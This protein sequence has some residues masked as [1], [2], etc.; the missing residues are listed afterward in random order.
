MEWFMI[1]KENGGCVTCIAEIPEDP[2]AIV[3]VAHGFTSC[4]ESATGQVLMQHLPPAGIGVVAYDQPG[5]GTDAARFEDLRI[6]NCLDSLAAVEE[7]VLTRWSGLPLFY[8]GSSYGAYITA[9]YLATRPHKGVRAVFRSAAVNMPAVMLG[10]DLSGPEDAVKEELQKN[11]Y[12]EPDLNLSGIVRIP[13]GFFEDLRETDLFEAVR[14]TNSAPG[15]ICGTKIAMVH[16]RDDEVV[17]FEKPERFSKEFGIPMTVFDGE[18]HNL[19]T[20]PATPDRMAE[21]ALRF[22]TAS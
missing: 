1:E 17:G 9:L 18:G 8:F 4:K 3:I 14:K 7:T 11:G 15:T 2:A 12:I 13:A 10:D 16:G 20:D 22:F 6:E 21:V 5:H 19:C